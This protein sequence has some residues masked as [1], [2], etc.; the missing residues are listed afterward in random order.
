MKYICLTESPVAKVQLKIGEPWSV[1][2]DQEQQHSTDQT[3]DPI[4][5]ITFMERQEDPHDFINLAEYHVASSTQGIYSIE[6]KISLS[7]G[8]KKRIEIPFLF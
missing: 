5:S 6:K 4:I 2:A 8:L 3:E 7:F 1:I